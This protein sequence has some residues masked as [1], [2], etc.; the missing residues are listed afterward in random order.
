MVGPLAAARE[1]RPGIPQGPQP[2]PP[3]AETVWEYF[4]VDLATKADNSHCEIQYRH[5]GETEPRRVKKD[6]AKLFIKARLAECFH[7]VYVRPRSEK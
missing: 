7:V 4:V 6:N 5:Y 3:P 2:Q 1:R